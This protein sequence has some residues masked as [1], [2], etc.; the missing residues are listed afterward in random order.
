MCAA[1]SAL[2]RTTHG[3][4]YRL[5]GARSRVDW[6][7]WHVSILV[8]KRLVL[9]E[10]EILLGDSDRDEAK[11]GSCVTA[12]GP[13]WRGWF[14]RLTLTRLAADEWKRTHN[15]QVRSWWPQDEKVATRFASR[16]IAW[17]DSTSPEYLLLQGMLP[18]VLQHAK[19]ITE[20]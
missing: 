4:R 7:A 3:V 8:G 19:Y 17:S 13:W 15:G 20:I 10:I 18:K 12:P 6:V 2:T 11:H 5:I 16:I 9:P 1:A 14:A